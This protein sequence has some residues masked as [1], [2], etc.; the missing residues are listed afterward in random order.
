[1]EVSG[2]PIFT[3]WDILTVS[4]STVTPLQKAS[5]QPTCKQ[6]GRYLESWGCPFHDVKPDGS[7]GQSLR[8]LRERDLWPYPDPDDGYP[9]DLLDDEMAAT[10]INTEGSAYGIR[11]D[12]NG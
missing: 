7:E 5:A 10:W 1:M 3:H 9:P 8:R 4:E 6:C 11:R 2:V 12:W